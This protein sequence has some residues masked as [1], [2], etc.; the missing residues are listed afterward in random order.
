MKKL[1]V[2]STALA[3]I[4]AS[5]NTSKSPSTSTAKNVDQASVPVTSNTSAEESDLGGTWE[6]VSTISEP[7][8]FKDLYPSV[9]PTIAFDARPKQVSGTTS[10]NTY[11]GSYSLDG[12]TISFGNGFALTKMACPGN[13]E[14]VFIDRI[15]KVNKFFIKD[16]TTLML[17]QD[18]VALLEF[19]KILGPKSY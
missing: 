4:F 18:D 11:T 1:I 6:L 16:Q 13:G 17:L 7:T 2:F 14:S 8:P 9:K 5:C 3:L 12:K 19:K 10:C 15:R